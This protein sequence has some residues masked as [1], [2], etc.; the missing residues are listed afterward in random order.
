MWS[1]QDKRK[2]PATVSVWK[3]TLFA[4]GPEQVRIFPACQGCTWPCTL[5]EGQQHIQQSPHTTN[6]PYAK[7]SQPNQNTEVCAMLGLGKK[8]RSHVLQKGATEP[9]RAQIHLPQ[10]HQEESCS[11]L[12]GL[13][14]CQP[15][16][17]LFSASCFYCFELPCQPQG[18]LLKKTN[19]DNSLTSF[20][21]TG[22]KDTKNEMEQSGTLFSVA[23]DRKKSAKKK[24]KMRL[25]IFFLMFV[26]QSKR[27]R[28][29][30]HCKSGAWKTSYK[31]PSEAHC[32]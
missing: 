14:C 4:Y 24:I 8:G 28:G 29:Q 2:A 11:A 27:R 7:W 15:L 25:R 5:C 21:W 26:F 31:W 12:K 10:W 9:N 6:V 1:N 20:I 18:H 3:W 13:L 19:N 17:P 22:H 32:R 16:Q 23:T 30:Q